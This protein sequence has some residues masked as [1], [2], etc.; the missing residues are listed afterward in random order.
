MKRTFTLL[1]CT[2]F[3]VFFAGHVSANVPVAAPDALGKCVSACNQQLRNIC[4]GPGNRNLAELCQG[5]SECQLCADDDAD[6]KGLSKA[7]VAAAENLLEACYLGTINNCP[8]NCPKGGGK[9]TGTSRKRSVATTGGGGQ[10]TSPPTVKD[11]C[12]SMD[13]FYV[14]EP[15]PKDR[16]KTVERCYTH[17]G[18]YTRLVQV[19]NALKRL[20]ERVNALHEGDEVPFDLRD[21]YNANKALLMGI[22]NAVLAVNK[23]LN[24]FVK[25]MERDYTRFGQRLDALDR[26]VTNLEQGLAGTQRQVNA[27]TAKLQ[28]SADYAPALTGWSLTPY[29]TFQAFTLYQETQYAFG[30]DLGVYPSLSKN[31]RNRLAINAGIGKAADYGDEGMVQHH[32]S[33]GYAYFAPAGSVTLGAGVNRYSLTDVQQGR[34]FWAGP[35]LEGRLNVASFGEQG[36]AGES[37]TLFL[38]GRAGAG[39]RWGRHHTLDTSVEP[40]QGRFD[41]P[42]FFGIGVQDVPFR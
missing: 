2:V 6:C 31:G 34:L 19:E 14:S 11:Q 9:A 25:R 12:R 20:T 21:D 7:D 23:D 24:N 29:A 38:M 5:V 30:A 13:G 8:K 16:N 10:P 42:F 27:N 17:Q 15:D 37:P 33:A 39:Y 28:N 22:D 40:V 41:M 36:G 35:L 3:A 26:R 4:P 1:A 32:V 18:V